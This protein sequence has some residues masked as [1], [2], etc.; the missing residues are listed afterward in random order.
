[1]FDVIEWIL[2]T[3]FIHLQ[4]FKKII[5]LT[6]WTLIRRLIRAEF[7]FIWW[8]KVAGSIKFINMSETDIILSSYTN[9]PSISQRYIT[10]PKKEE[11]KLFTFLQ[12]SFI[13]FFLSLSIQFHSLIKHYSYTVVLPNNIPLNYCSHSWKEWWKESFKNKVNKVKKAY[14]PIHRIPYNTI[15]TSW[16][17]AHKQSAFIKINWFFAHFT[18]YFFPSFFRP[19]SIH[20]W[21]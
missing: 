7:N 16:T 5:F 4:M 21:F 3:A 14:R 12:S 19:N 10:K 13:Q 9:K 17:N 11:K 20:C 2:R 8:L 18:C 1:M 6:N 15:H